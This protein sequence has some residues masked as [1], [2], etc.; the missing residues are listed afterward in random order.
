MIRFMKS[1]NTIKDTQSKMRDFANSIPSNEQETILM[2]IIQELLIEF[3][4]LIVILHL[5]LVPV[6]SFMIQ[7]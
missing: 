3:S 1:W 5:N 7:P 2:L 6:K 4:M